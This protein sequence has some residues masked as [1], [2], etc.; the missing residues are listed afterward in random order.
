[1]LKFEN[2][3]ELGDRIRAYDFEPMPGRDD[4]F[5]EGVVI[6]KGYHPEGYKCYT[7]LCDFDS[8]TDDATYSRVSHNVY[9][10]MGCSF[11][12]YDTRIQKV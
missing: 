4:R 5:V 7:I 9:V 3:A 8:S 10:P 1:M 6:D 2:T 12:E 11:F